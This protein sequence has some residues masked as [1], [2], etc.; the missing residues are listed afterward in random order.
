MCGIL[1]ILGAEDSTTMRKRAL[2][3]S[4]RLRHRGPDWSGIH[5]ARARA[6][7]D[8]DARVTLRARDVRGA[9]L[10]MASPY[11]APSPLLPQID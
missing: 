11:E 5:Q 2:D 10:P 6:P 1:A 9:A 7:G 3:L 8:R 4:R